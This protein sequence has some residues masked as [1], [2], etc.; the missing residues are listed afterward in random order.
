MTCCECHLIARDIGLQRLSSITA[1][2][3]HSQ[4]HHLP[5]TTMKPSHTLSSLFALLVASV[6]ANT[7]KTIF[8]AP[9]ALSFTDS[10]PGLD[11]L[12]LQSLTHESS[13]L[14]TS[15]DVLFPTQDAPQGSDHWFLLRD[16]NPGQ[17]YELRVC[18]PAVV[19]LHCSS[20]GRLASYTNP[21][22]AT[23]GILARRLSHRRGLRHARTHPESRRVR[24]EA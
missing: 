7:E 10:N 21:P 11:V 1:L 16:L 17:R 20:Q 18:W 2:R 13:T 14:T 4:Q 15:L 12:Q 19:R 6:H 23:D 8:I 3:D 5:P 24:W 9:D 22:P